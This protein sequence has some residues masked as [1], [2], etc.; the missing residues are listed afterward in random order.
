MVECGTCGHPGAHAVIVPP[1]GWPKRCPDCA[2]CVAKARA[3][4]EQG[5]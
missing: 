3:E 2:R 4:Q 5:E 1:E